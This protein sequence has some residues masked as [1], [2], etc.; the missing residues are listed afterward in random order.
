MQVLDRRAGVC[1]DDVLGGVNSYQLFMSRRE[2]PLT[3]I[4]FRRSLKPGMPST[5]PTDAYSCRLLL[6]EG[7]GLKGALR[8]FLS[9][10][11][12]SMTCRLNHGVFLHRLRVP[13]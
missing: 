7:S 6:D 8:R 2:D 10:F 12:G 11:Y 9:N 13:V 5:H 3:I 4:T 1:R